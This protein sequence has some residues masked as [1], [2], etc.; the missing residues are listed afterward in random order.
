MQLKCVTVITCQICL[1]SVANISSA[2]TSSIFSWWEMST[3]RRLWLD[4]A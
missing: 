3:Q 2:S 4:I 1:Q